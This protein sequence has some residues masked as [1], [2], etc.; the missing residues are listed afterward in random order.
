MARVSTFFPGRCCSKAFIDPRCYNNNSSLIL[1]TVSTDAVTAEFSGVFFGSEREKKKSYKDPKVDFLYFFQGPCFDLWQWVDRQVR[2][3]VGLYLQGLHQL[4]TSLAGAGLDPGLDFSTAFTVGGTEPMR[5]RRK[6]FLRG[7]FGS[8]R[9]GAR[10]SEA[11]LALFK[12]IKAQAQ[13][14]PAKYC[15][16]LKARTHKNHYLQP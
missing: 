9:Q 15:N 6:K 10:C 7:D 14:A 12:I 4:S 1:E 5:C 2:S 8:Y 11:L 3:V 13:S 16:E